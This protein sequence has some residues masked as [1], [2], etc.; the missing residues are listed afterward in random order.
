MV[1]APANPAGLP[2]WWSLEALPQFDV[3]FQ[4]NP[5]LDYKGALREW[6][7]VLGRPAL[8]PRA[9]FG[10]WWSRYYPYSQQTFTDEVLSGYAN[11]SIPL[12]MVVFDMDCMCPLP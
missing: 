10:V 3:Y 5:A 11:N 6:V 9:A 7:G 8:L 4:A 2:Q 12:N 1:A